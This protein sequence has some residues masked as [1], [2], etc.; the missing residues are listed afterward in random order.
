MKKNFNKVKA[1]F[2]LKANK[3]ASFHTF[4][5]SNIK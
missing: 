1:K 3:L 2:N 4:K 5:L